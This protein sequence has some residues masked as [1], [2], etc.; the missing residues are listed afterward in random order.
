MFADEVGQNDFTIASAGHGQLG[1]TYAHISSN[2]NA[3]LTA[4][5]SSLSSL[6]SDDNDNVMSMINYPRVTLD[7]M[8]ACYLTSRSLQ[9]GSLNTDT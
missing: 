3:V 5:S 4:S 7:S 8:K 6:S 2:G 9:D 1:V